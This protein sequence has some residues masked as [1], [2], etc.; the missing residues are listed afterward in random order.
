MKLL[1]TRITGQ[2]I[3]I[4]EGD[5]NLSVYV[6]KDVFLAKD[7]GH[8][9]GIRLDIIRIQIGEIKFPIPFVFGKDYFIG[10]SRRGTN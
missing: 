7:K 6:S 5:T 3:A 4:T 1:V 9:G 2:R 10:I 8:Q